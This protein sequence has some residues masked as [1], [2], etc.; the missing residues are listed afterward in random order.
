MPVMSSVQVISAGSAPWW[1]YSDAVFAVAAVDPATGTVTE[2][3]LL[4]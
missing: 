4:A 1:L 3:A 2:T